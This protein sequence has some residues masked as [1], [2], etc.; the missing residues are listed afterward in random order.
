[1]TTSSTYTNRNFSTVWDIA[2]GTNNGYP[3]IRSNG[4]TLPVTW[5]SFS[6]A[7]Q[8]THVAL[9]WSTASEQ[10]TKD[11]EIQYSTNTQTWSALGVVGAA[12]NS[13]TTRHYTFT[14]YNPLKGSVYNHYRIRQSD[15]DGKFSHSKIVSL[16][17]NEPGPDVQIYPNPAKDFLHIYIAESQQLRIVNVAGATVWQGWMNAGRNQVAIS[18][19]P[20]G[21][22]MLQTLKGTQRLLVQ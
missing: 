21:V 3:F 5:L 14:H 9:N 4:S 15:L 6:A 11:F 13:T 2:A 8:A 20:K 16:V 19:F 10:N 22:Y 18:H 12:G 1:M 7:K 17:Y